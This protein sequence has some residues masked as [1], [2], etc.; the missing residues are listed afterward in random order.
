MDGFRT[1]RAIGRRIGREHLEDLV[2]L[3]LDPEVSRYLGGVRTPET[4][5]E[6]LDTQMRHWDEHGFGLWGLHEPDGTFLGRAGIRF[7]QL[8]GEPVLEIAYSLARPAWGRGLAT[9]IAQGLVEQW[10]TRMSHP[11]LVGIVDVENIASE[12]VLGKCGFAHQRRTVFH[13]IDV[14]VFALTRG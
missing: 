13:D 7:T 9:E 3:H 14:N 10:R 4:T 12:R 2:R 8:D 1:A 6:Y 5:A 11:V